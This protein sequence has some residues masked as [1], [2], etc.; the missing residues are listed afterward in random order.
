MTNCNCTPAAEFSSTGADLELASRTALYQKIGS[1]ELS[2]RIAN[3]RIA[4]VENSPAA[5]MGGGN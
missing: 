3:R 1:A 5:T 2:A 4:E